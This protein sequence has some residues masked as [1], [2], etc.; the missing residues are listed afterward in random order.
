MILCFY[1]FIPSSGPFMLLISAVGQLGRRKIKSKCSNEHEITIS[2]SGKSQPNK[3]IHE[4][5]N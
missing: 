4:I 1:R 3:N 2:N 5:E